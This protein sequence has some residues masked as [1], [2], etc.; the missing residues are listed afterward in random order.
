MN[1]R[2]ERILEFINNLRL[3]GLTVEPTR[4]MDGSAFIKIVFRDGVFAEIVC[5]HRTNWR[6]MC[7]VNCDIID[8]TYRPGSFINDTDLFIQDSLTYYNMLHSTLASGLLSIKAL[9][10][11]KSVSYSEK[12]HEERMLLI[13]AARI[14]YPD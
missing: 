5:S 2:E 1:N 11:L 4:L 12:S 10:W 9:M 7:G 3:H 8:K 14:A 6:F 13:D